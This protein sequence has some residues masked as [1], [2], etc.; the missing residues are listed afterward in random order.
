M[1]VKVPTLIYVL[2]KY[3]DCGH[4]HEE[5]TAHTQ[6]FELYNEEFDYNLPPSLPHTSDNLI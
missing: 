2:N 4:Q 3:H 6:N 5:A 1:A